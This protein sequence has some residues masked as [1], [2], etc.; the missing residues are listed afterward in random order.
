MKNKGVLFLILGI[1]LINLVSANG[2]TTNDTVAI[3]KTVNVD[4]TFIF[5][6][7]NEEPFSFF[8]IT[9]EDNP[10]VEMETINELISGETRE[11][12]AT[13]TTNDDY[14]GPVEIIGF[15][16]ID[17]G[18]L[19]ETHDIDVDY[20]DGLSRCSF[21]IIKGDK[22]T[23]HNL[24]SDE[25]VLR[26]ADTGADV[27]TILEGDNYTMTF[28]IP[29]TFP[30]YFLRHG[31]VFTDVCEITALDSQGLV[32]NP[33]YN[34]V[35]NLNIDVEYEPTTL[36]LTTIQ[37]EYTMDA[38][39]QQEGV[40]TITNTGGK[41]AKNIKLEDAWF[42]FSPNNF[43]LEPGYSKNI[44]YTI[45]SIVVT[46]EETNM[47]HIRNVTISGNFPIIH[48][49]FDIFINYADLNETGGAGLSLI[50][51][52]KKWC[53]EHHDDEL[54]P[55]APKVIYR[56]GNESDRAFNVTMSEE[57]LKELF[58]LWFEKIYEDEV[59]QNFVKEK[60]DTQDG[61][62]SQIEQSQSNST[63]DMNNVLQA[64][65]DNNN[66]WIFLGIFFG[67]IVA[68]GLLTFIITN[69]RIRVKMKNWNR[70]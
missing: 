24:V 63:T 1:F 67:F 28:G 9:F 8:N 31:F 42:T 59:F 53:D 29:E 27:A 47:T 69:E 44:A 51:T 65:D 2:L 17:V 7:S 48:Q 37:T 22:V 55:Q 38:N 4:K 39:T 20:D 3:N 52:I 33:E 49:E 10:Y 14:I 50:D 18:Q 13:A 66:M 58:E 15:Y 70:W 43:D 32:N 23:W 6:L 61:R 62:M 57:Q 45:Q 35:L 19:N 41:V 11:I 30:Y 21:T 54:C 68:G 46:T 34:A 64:I 16:Q 60:F 25:I 26:N 5:S 56:Y 12:T 36:S 40:M